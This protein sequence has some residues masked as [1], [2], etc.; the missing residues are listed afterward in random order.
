MTPVFGSVVAA[1][2]APASPHLGQ[3]WYKPET[4]V[5]YQYTND[6]ATNFGWIFLLVE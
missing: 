1:T 6:G 5:T 3:R 4:A 2:T